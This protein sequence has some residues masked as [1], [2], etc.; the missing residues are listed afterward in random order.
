MK[1]KLIAL[2][3]L[4]LIFTSCTKVE[5]KADA[6]GNFEAVE[7]IIS[8]EAQGKLI[9]FNLN[10][11]EDVTIGQSIG[12][13]DTSMLVLQRNEILANLRALKFKLPDVSKDIKVLEQQ[14]ANIEVDRKRTENLLEKKAATQ[15]QYD[16]IIAQIEVLKKQITAAKYKESVQSKAILSEIEPIEAKLKQINYSIDKCKIINPTVGTVIS[17]FVEENEIV[18]FGKALYKVA[19]LE[20]III[21]VYV[22][23]PQMVNI[24]IG[25]EV[26]VLVDAP[27]ETMKEYAGT[28]S[29]ISSKAEFTPKIIQTKEERI[30][31]VYAVKIAVKN[32]GGLKLGMPGEV[33]F[34]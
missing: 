30:N 7:T 22:S 15:K 13:I 23:E 19:D 33:Y 11:G 26:K 10:E 28:I 29:W 6:Y 18:S 9:T 14:I 8:A 1:T 5:E 3:I 27:K 12:L 31:L 25:A 32:D 34:K 20:N 16:D 17:K 2:I 24:K 21:R 4:G